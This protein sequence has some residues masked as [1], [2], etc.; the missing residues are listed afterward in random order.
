MTTKNPI[1]PATIPCVDYRFIGGSE[2]QTQEFPTTQAAQEF[3]DSIRCIKVE[4]KRE[5][6]SVN[7]EITQQAQVDFFVQYHK[8][9]A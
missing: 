1:V 8:G 3:V 2:V 4:R 6:G 9:A 5:D 7:D